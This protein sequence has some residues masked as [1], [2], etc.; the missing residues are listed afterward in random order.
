MKEQITKKQWVIIA[1]SL[2]II[3]VVAIHDI[4]KFFIA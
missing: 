3:S 2:V 4:I 1:A